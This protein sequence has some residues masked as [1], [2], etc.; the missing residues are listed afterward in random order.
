M[1]FEDYIIDFKYPV[2]DTVRKVRIPGT[3]TASYKQRGLEFKIQNFRYVLEVL[4]TPL[5]IFKDT[6]ALDP[7]RIAII[8]RVEEVMV[9]NGVFA[10]LSPNM[11]YAVYIRDDWVMYD[12]QIE[13]VTEDGG[14]YPV[15]RDGRY[16]K[17]LWQTQ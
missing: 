2:D 9:R 12:H 8:G 10:T 5:V 13:F 4:N 7:G 1:G 16:G 14:Y 3:L 6:R 15:N 11:V 17:I